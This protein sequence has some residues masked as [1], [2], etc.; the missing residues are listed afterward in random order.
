MIQVILGNCPSKSNSYR[1]GYKKLLKTDDLKRYEGNFLLQCNKYR[2]RNI[3]RPFRL[4][5][6]VYFAAMKQ[7]LDNSFKII[8]DCLQTCKAIS[9]DNLCMEIAARKDI[10]KKNTRIEFKITEL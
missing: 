8:L 1:I 5:I 4:D 7:D 6:V 9:N 10:D 3:N 2:N